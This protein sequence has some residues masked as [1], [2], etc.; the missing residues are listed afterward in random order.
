MRDQ[1]TLPSSAGHVS[2]VTRC[3]AGDSAL[4]APQNAVGVERFEVELDE[5]VPGV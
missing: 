3:R 5:H 2:G 1:G 4:Q